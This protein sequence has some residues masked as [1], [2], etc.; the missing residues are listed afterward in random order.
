MSETRKK[1]TDTQFRLLINAQIKFD[2][3]AAQA[4][5]TREYL[6]EIRSLVLDA[7]SIPTEV[8]VSIDPKTQE[9]VIEERDLETVE[10]PT[11]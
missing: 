1:L 3:A 9:L 11:E 4:N 8:L 7:H 10:E 6:K 5:E 2:E